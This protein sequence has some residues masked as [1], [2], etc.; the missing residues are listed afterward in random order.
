MSRF[1][2]QA[3]QMGSPVITTGG[4]LV[5]DIQETY[6]GNGFFSA[7]MNSYWNENGTFLSPCYVPDMNLMTIKIDSPDV[8]LQMIKPGSARFYPL[9]PQ[10]GIDLSEALRLANEGV[11]A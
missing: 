1:S 3:M 2:K 10:R 5:H 6:S 4:V 7:S 9:V 8:Q 11:V